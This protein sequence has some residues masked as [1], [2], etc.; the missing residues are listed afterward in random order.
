MPHP[1]KCMEI[2]VSIKFTETL[3]R[4]AAAAA[5]HDEK[6]FGEYVR[7]C[8]MKDL[9][10]KDAARRALNIIFEDDHD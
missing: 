10:E 4:R 2:P 1:E 9:A 6:S 5:I 8:V 3:R 7:G